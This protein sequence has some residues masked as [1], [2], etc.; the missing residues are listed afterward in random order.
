MLVVS[1]GRAYRVTV[2]AGAVWRL[3]SSRRLAIYLILAAVLLLLPAAFFPQPPPGL[4]PAAQEAWWAQCRARLGE[5]VNALA[6]IGWIGVARSPILLG[7]ASA[8]LLNGV[9]CTIDR[10]GRL[11]R[12]ATHPS[13]AVLPEGAYER[14]SVQY[15]NVDAARFPRELA[16]LRPVASP[17]SRVRYFYG[18]R[19]RWGPLGTILS[20]LGLLLFLAAAVAHLAGY[21]RESLFLQPG[22]ESWFGNRPGCRFT[23]SAAAKDAPPG[24]FWIEAE[25]DGQ[26]KR[27]PIAPARPARA[28]GARLYLETYG[29]AWQAE[30]RAADGRVL[31]IDY[32]GG[33]GWLC[34]GEGQTAG[35]FSLPTEGITG[36]V[37]PSPAG[38]LGRPDEALQLRIYGPGEALLFDGTVEP[39]GQLSVAEVY[40]SWRTQVFVKLEAVVEP[41]FGWMVAGATC[42]LVGMCA[43]LWVRPR[44]MWARWTADGV[45]S[46][47]TNHR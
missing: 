30:V 34:F 2:L 10:A 26:R 45:L 47:V 35:A 11:W 29:L 42:L 22:T 36:T 3:L 7:V 20:H 23:V 9:A 12:A 13:T 15:A 5:R 24:S 43:A 18:E 38:L 27:A 25:A 8:L 44:R 1:M 19:G 32:P 14:A 33:A 28:C 46:V 16:W 31:P 17:S 41:G 40:L 21:R 39:T 4:D 6:R 37:V